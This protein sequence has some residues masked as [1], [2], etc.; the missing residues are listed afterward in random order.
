MF[1]V[2]TM[3][4]SATNGVARS[5]PATRMRTGPRV[6]FTTVEEKEVGI[7]LILKDYKLFLLYGG[8]RE[9][10]LHPRNTLAHAVAV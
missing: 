8:V 7:W 9:R 3:P 1:R 10:P 4:G 6:V 5:A 2:L